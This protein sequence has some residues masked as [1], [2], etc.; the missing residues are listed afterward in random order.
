[1]FAKLY[2]GRAKGHDLWPKI[3]KQEITTRDEG[4]WEGETMV[5]T[6]EGN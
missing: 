3:Q 6:S 1:M 4:K 5:T 2:T